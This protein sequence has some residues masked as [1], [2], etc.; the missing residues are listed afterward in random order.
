[1][2]V[3]GKGKAQ[4]LAKTTQ[5]TMNTESFLS[6][7]TNEQQLLCRLLEQVIQQNEENEKSKVLE[8]LILTPHQDKK[9]KPVEQV[10]Q[11]NQLRLSVATPLLAALIQREATV[12]AAVLSLSAS[13]DDAFDFAQELVKNR[14]TEIKTVRGALR[15][16]DLLIEEN[17][18]GQ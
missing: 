9:E 14:N 2:A 8:L 7:L 11:D 6:D 3:H 15:Y 1:L 18:K 5:S 16:A 12:F 13:E 10:A 17:R 4:A